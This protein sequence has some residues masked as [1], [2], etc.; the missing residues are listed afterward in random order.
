MMEKITV[1][2]YY[3]K[4]NC[5]GTDCEDTCCSGWWNV[6]I[7]WKTFQKYQQ[8][9]QPELAPLFKIAVSKNTLPSADNKNNDENEAGWGMSFLPNG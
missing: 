2:D 7:D 3:L 9:T 5:I 4:F 1:P 8:S 6:S